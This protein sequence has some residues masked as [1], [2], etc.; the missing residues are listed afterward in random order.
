MPPTIPSLSFVNESRSLPQTS[1][2]RSDAAVCDDVG[3]GER[4]SRGRT[5]W[6][7][8]RPCLLLSH[9]PHRRGGRLEAHPAVERAAAIGI[10]DDVLGE[11]ICACILLEEGALVAPDEI[12]DWCRVALADYKVPDQVRVFEEFP[13]TSSGKIRR[14]ELARRISER[15]GVD[16]GA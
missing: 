8:S 2:F 14:A 9:V 13:V 5:A 1:Y 6:R 4:D 10:P 12:R 16:S 11:A 7:A 15:T 3:R